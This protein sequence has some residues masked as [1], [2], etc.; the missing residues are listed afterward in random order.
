MTPLLDGALDDYCRAHTKAPAPL[1][2][3]LI[4]VTRARMTDH[5][6]QVGPVEGALL[7]LLVR[8]TGAERV[9]E[10]GTFTG[11]SALAMAEALPDRGRL[12]TCDIDPIATA[13]ARD[14]FGRSPHGAKIELRL[15]DAMDTVRAF[16]PDERFDMIFID[17]DKGRYPAYFEALLPRLRVGG[18]FV[19][20]NCLWSGEVVAPKTGDA[21]AIDE[22]NRRVN[23]DPRVENVLLSVRDGV[24]IARRVA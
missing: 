8:L 21:R 10:I 1:L 11:Y 3:E 19:A 4:Q 17:A 15:G 12:V 23:A 18:L 24:M 6:M 9:L 20:D 5:Q 7:G 13:I 14:F 16:G 2:A 22:L